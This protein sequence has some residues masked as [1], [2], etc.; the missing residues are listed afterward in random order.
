M[1]KTKT[2]I[3]TKVT[4]KTQGSENRPYYGY[5]KLDYLKQ[6]ALPSANRKVN[7]K[8]HLK[9]KRKNRDERW[10]N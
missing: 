3:N 6:T 9:N 2:K 10:T 7:A 1:N 8:F 5:I 4:S